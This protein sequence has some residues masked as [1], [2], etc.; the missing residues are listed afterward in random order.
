MMFA[1]LPPPYNEGLYRCV[2]V[3]MGPKGTLCNAKI[4]GAPHELHH[5]AD[6]NAH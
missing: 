6:G 1:Q 5:H 4:P 2:S 3:D